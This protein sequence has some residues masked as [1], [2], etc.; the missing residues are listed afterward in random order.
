MRLSFNCTPF[1]ICTTFDIHKSTRQEWY[2]W[3]QLFEYGANLV[4]L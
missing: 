4:Q 1:D 2:K 3:L